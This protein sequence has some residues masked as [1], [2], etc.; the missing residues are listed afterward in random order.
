V[1]FYENQTKKISWILYCNTCPTKK[2]KTMH[3]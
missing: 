2:L 3:A 1:V